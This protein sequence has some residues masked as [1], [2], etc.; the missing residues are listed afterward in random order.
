MRGRLPARALLLGHLPEAGLGSA[1]LGVQEERSTS[2]RV[3]ESAT[4][5]TVGGERK[6]KRVTL[7]A[8]VGHVRVGTPLAPPHS[9]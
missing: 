3:G 1:P 9:G 8:A 7:Q 4:E 5:L 6:I 2:V